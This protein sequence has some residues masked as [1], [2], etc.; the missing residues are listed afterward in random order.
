MLTLCS[1][2]YT[3]Q[4]SK[5]DTAG[6]PAAPPREGKGKR[7]PADAASEA[8]ARTDEPDRAAAG[9]A[10]SSAAP[11]DARKPGGAGPFGVLRQPTSVSSLQNTLKNE[12]KTRD[13]ELQRIEREDEQRAALVVKLEQEVFEKE[14][15]LN[16]L[17]GSMAKLGIG[18]SLDLV[19]PEDI[20]LTPEGLAAH[21]RERLQRE[22]QL[23]EGEASELRQRVGA[24]E[25]LI[26]EK[27]AEVVAKGEAT[28]QLLFQLSCTATQ[29]RINTS[30]E[31]N[32]LMQASPAVVADGDAA[33]T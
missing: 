6:D 21:E 27:R 19:L 14:R 33:S 2:I 8:K 15:E 29:Q 7:G 25:E 23:R 30:L 32:P 18:E 9:G 10:S 17:K 11:G 3:S 24:L 5:R 26:R 22:I 16:D 4:D 20:N 13:E 28:L 12:V 31:G 1:E